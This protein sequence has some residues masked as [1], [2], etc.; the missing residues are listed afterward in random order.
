MGVF[1][2][3][4]K[5]GSVTTPLTPAEAQASGKTFKFRRTWQCG[6]GAQMT[7][8]G[9]EDR[10]DGPSNFRAYPPTH[11]LAGHSMLPSEALT[12]NGLAEERGWKVT[13]RVKCPACQHGVDI[14]T[15]KQA[16]RDGAL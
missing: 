1:D 7:I 4:R 2:F 16:K 11:R 14:A 3:F 13:P 5:R 8:R 15:Y 9:R 10:A 12:W 6:C